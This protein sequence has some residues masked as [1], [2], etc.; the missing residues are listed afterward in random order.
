VAGEVAIL[1][2][3]HPNLNRIYESVAKCFAQCV[4]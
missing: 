2:H 4:A 1:N 3:Q